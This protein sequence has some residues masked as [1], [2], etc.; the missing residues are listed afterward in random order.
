MGPRSTV[1]A[2]SGAAVRL[3]RPDGKGRKYGQAVLH[4]FAA[5]LDHA[6]GRLVLLV[7]AGCLQPSQSASSPLLMWCI[8]LPKSCTTCNVC[9]AS[10][11]LPASTRPGLSG[12]H[13]PIEYAAC[14]AA[15]CSYRGLPR[16]IVAAELQ[17]S[18]PNT[19]YMLRAAAPCPYCW[20]RCSR[21]GFAG[22]HSGRTATEQPQHC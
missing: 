21:A 3:Q 12:C 14:Q 7:C 20:C 6:L 22:V 19:A 2:L 16:W 1:N 17:Q 9:A 15:G 11:T 18:D 5:D 8:T 10:A 4:G 13:Q